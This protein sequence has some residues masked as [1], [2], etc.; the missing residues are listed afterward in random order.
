MNTIN[1]LPWREASRRERRR[2][3][4]ALL[5]LAAL[6][7][8]ALV[9]LGSAI[10]ARRLAIQES[11]NQWLRSESL[12]LASQLE[13]IRQLDQ[14]L[15][16]LEARRAAVEGLQRSRGQVV[17]LLDA[18]ASRVP[19][20][21]ALRSVRQ[22]ERITLTGWA[23]SNARVSGLLR[24]LDQM[25]GTRGA[26]ELVEV[27]AVTVG[28]GRDARRLFEFTL[29]LQPPAMA[30]NQ[31]EDPGT[32]NKGVNPAGSKSATGSGNQANAGTNAGANA[33]G[34]LPPGPSPATGRTSR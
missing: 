34:G 33:R 29:V 3:F 1:L 18:L 16:A 12:K 32:G 22:A 26:P 17:Q 19:E 25:P 10:N 8:V 23:Q 2:Q 30:A 11:R 24:Q 14:A 6:T 21:I 15:A 27:K 20:G 28:Q 4:H 7:G 5:L 31:K 9:F 13:E